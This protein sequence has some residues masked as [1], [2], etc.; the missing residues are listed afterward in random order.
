MTTDALAPEYEILRAAIIRIA[1]GDE[2]AQKI[3]DDA[4]ACLSAA[5]LAAAPPTDCRVDEAAVER[6]MAILWNAT[7]LDEETM[8]RAL[9]AA[10]STRLAPVDGLTA[11][12]LEALATLEGML[13]RTPAERAVCAALRRLTGEKK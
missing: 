1:M 2:P 9:T 5:M 3:A 10:I 8:R 12:E 7:T 13:H 11:D 6:G 4:L